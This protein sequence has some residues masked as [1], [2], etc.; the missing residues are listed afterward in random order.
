MHFYSFAKLVGYNEEIVK[1]CLK[2]REKKL[3]LNSHPLNH[4]QLEKWWGLDLN[5]GNH[6]FKRVSL[7][8]S[9]TNIRL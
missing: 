1:K 3:I 9:V 2:Q 7:A 6:W 8:L 5:D 4:I